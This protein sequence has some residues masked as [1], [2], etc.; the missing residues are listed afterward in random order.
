MPATKWVPRP[1]P[2][3]INASGIGTL[4]DEEWI[5]KLSPAAHTALLARANIPLNQLPAEVGIES[6]SD[7]K[8]Y[9]PAVKLLREY[10]EKK[11]PIVVSMDY[12][13]DGITAGCC[14]YRTLKLAGANVNWVV[15]NRNDHGYGMNIELITSHTEGASLI[16]TVDNGITNVAET[17]ELHLRGHKVLI[18]DHHLQ[19]GD[20][21][22][23]DAI[24]NPKLFKDI[25]EQH[26]WD[27]P[28]NNEYMAPGVYVGAKVA[29]A[30][31]KPL[32]TKEIYD[33]AA[34]YCHQLVAL[35][36]VS[37]VIEL[38]EFLIHEL[39]TGLAL[40]AD[41]EFLGIKNLLAVANTKENQPITSSFC[42]FSI[43]P[44][45][46]SC[47]RMCHPEEAVKLLLMEDS[48]TTNPT[49]ALRAA[50]TLK[51]LNTDR[52]LLENDTFV[53]CVRDAVEYLKTHCDT[54]VLF[55]NGWHIGILGIL[56]ARIAEYFHRPTIILS[57]HKGVLEGSGR[58]I[59]GFDLF[60]TIQECKD[61][62]VRF[63]GHQ[64]A[65]GISLT[66]AN[67]EGFR[68]K[69]EELVSTKG[70]PTELTY[71]YDT[72]VDIPT[73]H[74]V[75]W[76]GFMMNFEPSGNLNPPLLLVLRNVQIFKCEKNKDA[77]Y[78]S[79]YKDGVGIR[80]SRYRAPVEWECLTHAWV[81]LLISPNFLYFTGYT[82][83]DYRLVDLHV[84]SMP[85][86]PSLPEEK[87]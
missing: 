24:C 71:E 50:N 78:F 4:A 13:C 84:I 16:V 81:D 79:I 10:V 73:L 3:V 49:D 32:V 11:L 34:S 40:L 77:M 51:Y 57:E 9:E 31:I 74:D 54:I 61:L 43:V 8:F 30:A 63:G 20:L 76:Q 23:A 70:L 65:I 69:F 7:G 17:A 28:N 85:A 64:A 6:D 80:I 75:R 56:A 47:G 59:E 86:P 22:E 66:E 5:T 19:E 21:P 44:K 39:R 72:E 52:K 62:L 82:Q 12:D 46:N 67:L 26:K 15:P 87:I 41:T 42:S 45:I 33:N 1:V 68:T 35:G 25:A 36:I 14:V 38:N 48:P 27:A 29:L 83:I 37:D 2:E 58:T 55:R 18:T 53:E 60:H